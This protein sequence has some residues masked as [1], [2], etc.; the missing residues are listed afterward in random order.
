ML[1]RSLYAFD[2]HLKLPRILQWN[3]ALEQSLGK[4]QTITASYIGSAGR[5]LLQTALI[6]SPNSNLSYA[7]LV[8][9]AGTSDYN[10]LQLQFQRRFSGGFQTLASYSWSHSIDTASAGSVGS[11]SNDLS[12]LDSHVNSGPSDFDHRN[13]FSIALTYDVPSPKW[14]TFANAVLRGW[15]T[16]NVVQ[17]QSAPPVNVYYSYLGFGELSGGFNTN[18]RPDVIGSQPFYLYGPQYPGGKS[19]NSTSTPAGCPDGSDM[20]GPF[21]PPPTVN[22]LPTRQGN[23]GRNA[24]RGFG[25]AQ[26]DFA[27]HR[28][29]R[30]RET[31]KLQ[32]RAELFNL[33]NHPNFGPPVGDMQLP[34]AVNPQF[35]RSIQMLGQS[36]SGGNLGSGGF[37]PLYQVGGPRSIQFALKLFF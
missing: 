17:A 16:E 8:T 12:A 29:F 37:S 33:L 2:P 11:G 9:N 27:V 18:P 5:R 32:F 10:A 25:V 15:S 26:W 28:D 31:V 34:S 35:G 23:L 20:V 36:L 30:I 1:F 3:V 19:I 13:A 4:Q 21:C 6:S 22:G 24:L 14:N 7:D